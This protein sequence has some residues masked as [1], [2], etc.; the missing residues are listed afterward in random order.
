M[1][2]ILSD[3]EV[4]SLFQNY[5]LWQLAGLGGWQNKVSGSL[6]PVRQFWAAL[7]VSCHSFACGTDHISQLCIMSGNRKQKTDLFFH[8][9]DGRYEPVASISSE[10]ID[11]RPATQEGKQTS[12]NLPIPTKGQNLTRHPWKMLIA[13]EGPSL[14]WVV[15]LS[16]R[17]GQNSAVGTRSKGSSS[18]GM[19]FKKKLLSVYAASWLVVHIFFKTLCLLYASSERCLQPQVCVNKSW[20]FVWLALFPYPTLTLPKHH[21]H[22]FFISWNVE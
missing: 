15:I 6:L 20:L 22:L 1:S 8:S 18:A 10:W 5:Q 7:L 21:K 16:I 2:L 11:I 19:F 3:V 14:T 4:Q 13:M 12:R 9:H 17:H